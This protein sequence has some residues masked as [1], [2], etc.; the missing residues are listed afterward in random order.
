MKNY[1]D[2]N[3]V[4]LQIKREGLILESAKTDAMLINASAMFCDCLYNCLYCFAP[5]RDRSHGS[6][7]KK[8]GTITS[9]KNLKAALAQAIELAE[10]ND[11]ASPRYS[12]PR[13]LNVDAMQQY[14]NALLRA[15]EVDNNNTKVILKEM[16]NSLEGIVQTAKEIEEAEEKINENYGFAAKTDVLRKELGDLLIRSE[17][18]DA[19]KGY[20]KNWKNIFTAFDQKIRGLASRSGTSEKDFAMLDSLKKD[21]E[22]QISAFHRSL[23]DS[24]DKMRSGVETDEAA[25]KYLDVVSGLKKATEAYNRAQASEETVASEVADVNREKEENGLSAI[26]PLKM[27]DSDDRGRFKG[28]KIIT[29]LHDAISTVPEFADVLKNEEKSKFGKGMKVCIQAIQ[30]QSGNNNPTGEIDAAL[31]SALKNSDW[32]EMDDRVAMDE[33]VIEII[34]DKKK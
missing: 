20:Q 17:G 33:I 25:D 18:K 23:V 22:K 29:L 30:K 1:Y 9:A 16:R 31:Y 28:R 7:H 6:L 8:F 24:F 5:Q 11:L 21:L 19:S 14:A 3:P 32:L 34:S 2:I 12:E 27:G 4:A 15:T 10:E 13:R 26:F